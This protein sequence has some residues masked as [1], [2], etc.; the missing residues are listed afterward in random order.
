MVFAF[1]LALVFIVN[2]FILRK[3]PFDKTRIFFILFISII[4]SYAIPTQSL[5]VLPLAGQWI[6]GALVT[7]VPLFFA[8]MLFSQILATRQEPI[9]SLGYKLMGAICEGLLEYSSM[10]L[11][12]KNLYLLALVLYILD[13][14]VH[15]REKN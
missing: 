3:G 15:G 13:F 12:T 4:I 11:G 5:L 14:L 2:L 6:L 10:A 7:A 9:T 1:I 8:R